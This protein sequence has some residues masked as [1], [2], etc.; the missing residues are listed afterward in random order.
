VIV[1]KQRILALEADPM[2]ALRGRR[3]NDRIVERIDTA[4]IDSAAV[5]ESCS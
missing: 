5:G 4:E 2:Q 3:M 1:G